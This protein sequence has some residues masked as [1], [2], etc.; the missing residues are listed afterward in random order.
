VSHS[1]STAGYRAYLTR[2]PDQHISVAVLCNASNGTADR[3]AHAVADLYLGDAIKPRPGEVENPSRDGVPVTDAVKARAGMYR[4]TANG[5]VLTIVVDKTGL[6]LEG[7]AGPANALV[8][9][10][11]STFRSLAGDRT[12]RFDTGGGLSVTAQNGDV[13]TYERVEPARP[14]PAQLEAY[15]GTYDSDEA[16]V[17]LQVAVENGALRVTRRPD[18]VLAL[19]PLYEDGFTAPGL[20]VVR[21]RRDAS[22]RVVALSV[23]L[24]RVWDLRFTR[25]PEAARDEVR[26][27]LHGRN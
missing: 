25:R 10:A 14:T 3:Y 20:G 11:G 24:D 19:R 13:E 27:L 26:V 21:F 17:T 12:F 4:S 5:R 15:A 9:E 18:T 8:P 1:G 23:G 16:E 6:R 7:A 22:R 2:Y